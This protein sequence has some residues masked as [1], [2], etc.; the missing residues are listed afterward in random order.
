MLQHCIAGLVIEQRILSGE[1]TNLER[2]FISKL[3]FDG[4]ELGTQKSVSECTK[5]YPLSI[6]IESIVKNI[7]TV[8][9]GQPNETLW[10]FGSKFFT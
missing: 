2:T 10:T 1:P 5:K 9:F 3:I 7:L 6:S 4:G 8:S